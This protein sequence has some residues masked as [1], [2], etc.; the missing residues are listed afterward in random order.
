MR[1]VAKSTLKKFWEQSEYHDA[2]G[3]L[4]SWHEE[5]LRG[6]EKFGF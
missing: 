2:Q 5:A 1:I 4:E 6:C 3:P